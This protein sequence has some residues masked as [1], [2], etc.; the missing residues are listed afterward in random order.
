MSDAGCHLAALH[1]SSAEGCF[2]KACEK[3][4]AG[5]TWLD[6]ALL[7]DTV[8]LCTPPPSLKQLPC[9]AVVTYYLCCNFL[10]FALIV[11]DVGAC[12]QDW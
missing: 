6:A 10:G 7:L 8:Y 11:M 12:Q 3:L 1:I 2:Q 4:A 5:D 9:C